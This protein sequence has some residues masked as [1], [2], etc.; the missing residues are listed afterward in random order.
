MAL[1][2]GLIGCG[3]FSQFHQQAWRRM[4]SD[5]VDVVAA[6]D[7]QLDRAEAAAPRA[8]ADAAEMLRNEQLDAL[9]IAT[10]PETHLDLVR[11]AAERGISVICQKPLAPSWSE[12]QELATVVRSSGI[13]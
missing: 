8:Y 6:C 9:D 4:E 11:M 12:V 2:I 10:R 7:P 1:R 3:Y 13:R 5:G